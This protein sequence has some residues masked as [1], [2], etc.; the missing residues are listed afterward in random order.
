VTARMNGSTESRRSCIVCSAQVIKRLKRRMR[1]R[2]SPN[3]LRQ[4]VVEL[5]ERLIE[6]CKWIIE[7]ST[8]VIAP[9]ERFIERSEYQL[10]CRFRDVNRPDAQASRVRHGVRSLVREG[11]CGVRDGCG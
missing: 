9:S 6:S 11:T 3:E 7:L 2:G 1:A 5:R 4:R 8:R 10:M